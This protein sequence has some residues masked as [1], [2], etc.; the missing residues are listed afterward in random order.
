MGHAEELH[1]RIVVA[2]ALAQV[3]GLE[4]GD[5]SRPLGHGVRVILAPGQRHRVALERIDEGGL[6]HPVERM[7][8][9]EI[10]GGLHLI[11]ERR[12]DLPRLGG[13][14]LDAL[15]LAEL[16]AVPVEL[17]EPRQADRFILLFLRQH[18][19]LHRHLTRQRRQRFHLLPAR[20]AEALRRFSACLHVGAERLDFRRILHINRRQADLIAVGN[21]T[22]LILD[23]AFLHMF[24]DFGRILRVHEG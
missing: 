17:L 5:Q 7:H 11:A 1:R 6:V 2:R 23:T 19:D 8:A 4:I 14:R 10:G 9:A 16:Q 12:L 20:K 21:E 22:E 3:G 13:E 24:D 15:L 18:A